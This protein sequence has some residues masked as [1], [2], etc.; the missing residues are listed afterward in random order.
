M[1]LVPEAPRPQ[2]TPQD[3]INFRTDPSRADFY[4]PPDIASAKFIK[5]P[6]PFILPA[7]E[8]EIFSKRKVAAEHAADEGVIGVPFN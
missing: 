1:A 3:L 5:D 4:A 8:W 2:V 7:Q 6:P